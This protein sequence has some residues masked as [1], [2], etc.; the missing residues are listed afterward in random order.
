MPLFLIARFL[1]ICSTWPVCL[2]ILSDKRSL[3]IL[4]LYTELKEGNK[5]VAKV[6]ARV[7]D[8]TSE[9]AS[10]GKYNCSEGRN[11]EV[12]SRKRLLRSILRNA[13]KHDDQ[14]MLKHV[15]DCTSLPFLIATVYGSFVFPLSCLHISDSPTKR[16]PNIARYM[17]E[18]LWHKNQLRAFLY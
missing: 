15:A 8:S 2:S 7:L 3:P 5:A 9:K 1:L 18:N 17:A 6:L 10:R 11:W 13:E 4:T 12:C 16:S 14:R